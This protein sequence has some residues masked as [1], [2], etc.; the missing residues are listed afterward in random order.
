MSS[1]WNNTKPNQIVFALTLCLALE[2][3]RQWLFNVRTDLVLTRA[4]FYGVFSQSQTGVGKRGIIYREFYLSHQN[5]NPK[6]RWSTK[7]VGSRQGW[8]VEYST[9]NDKVVSGWA[10]GHP[11]YPQLSS[12]VSELRAIQLSECP[13]ADGSARSIFIRKESRGGQGKSL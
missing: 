7:R 6:V 1:F 9:Y 8:G 3:I 13:R 4:S 11:I 2:I 12:E 5:L 10:S